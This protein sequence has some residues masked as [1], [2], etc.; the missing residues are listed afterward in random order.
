MNARPATM[1]MI[2]EVFKEDIMARPRHAH[3]F[4]VPRL[5]TYLW[6]KQL[7]NDADVFM[8]ITVR[9]H[10]WEKSQHEPLI[11]AIVLHFAHVENYSGPWIA[12]GL[13]KPG[14]LWKEFEAC[15]TI[16]GDRNPI[17]CPCMDGKLCRTWE[18]SE[19]RN[20]R[21]VLLKLL[22]WAQGFPPCGGV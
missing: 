2:M 6:R 19:G 1:E 16:A 7:G 8:T 15:F 22:G 5:M 4:V 20:N 13:E 9:D 14:T 17:Q 3:V 11:L 18:D 21:T 12:C 10:S